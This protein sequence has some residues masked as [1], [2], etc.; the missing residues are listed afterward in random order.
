MRRQVVQV[1]FIELEISDFVFKK[2]SRVLKQTEVSV[3]GSDHNLHSKNRVHTQRGIRQ[4]IRS[5][6]TFAFIKERKKE[7]IQ[8]WGMEIT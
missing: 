2:I 6:T 3:W 8:S 7:K 1:T 4:E 5:Y